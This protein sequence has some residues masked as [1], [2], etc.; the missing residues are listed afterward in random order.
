[1]SKTLGEMIAVAEGRLERVLTSEEIE[2]VGRMLDAEKSEDEILEVLGPEEEEVVIPADDE[3][4]TYRYEGSPAGG[5]IP[6]P[7]AAPEDV[8]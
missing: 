3:L 8:A 4:E 5:V 6:I 7:P 2:I 1:M